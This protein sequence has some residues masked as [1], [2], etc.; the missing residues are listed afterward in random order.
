METF[1]AKSSPFPAFYCKMIQFPKIGHKQSLWHLEGLQ[2]DGGKRSYTDGRG[3]LIPRGGFGFS[4]CLFHFLSWSSNECRQHSLCL[5]CFLV[6]TKGI[7]HTS[8]SLVN[9]TL[10]SP[11]KSSWKPMIRKPEV[12]CAFH[13]AGSRTAFTSEEI[14]GT[15]RVQ[16]FTWRSR[17]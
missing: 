14:F 4:R 5:P 10:T 12:R 16:M 8:Y 2:S 3:S 17:L 1:G 13:A 7:I 6:Q 9:Q 15:F 11:R